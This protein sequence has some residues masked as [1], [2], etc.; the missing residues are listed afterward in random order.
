MLARTPMKSNEQQGRTTMK[1]LLTIAILALAL[2]VGIAASPHDARASDG[3]YLSYN[4][5]PFTAPY[6]HVTVFG[7]AYCSIYP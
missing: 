7:T 2:T 5:C 4:P 3:F 1:K 6:Q